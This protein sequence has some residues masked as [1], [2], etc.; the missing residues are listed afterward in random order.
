MFGFHA[1]G[2]PGQNDLE[3]GHDSGTGFTIKGWVPDYLQVRLEPDGGGELEGIERF[4]DILVLVINRLARTGGL[5][6]DQSDA[7][8]II[9]QPRDQ[10]QVSQRGVDQKA[11]ANLGGSVG[12]NLLAGEAEA[13]GPGEGRMRAQ[14]L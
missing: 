8:Q 11:G 13:A 7:K 12:R 9:A 10:P 1:S 3:L 5:A 14:L 4:Q 6:P 2:S